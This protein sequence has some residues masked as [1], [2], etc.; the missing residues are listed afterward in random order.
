[1][2][3]SKEPCKCTEGGGGTINF[4]IVC[5]KCGDNKVEVWNSYGE[6]E[7]SVIL[8]CKNCGNKDI[9]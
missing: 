8:K 5:R 2:T 3:T 6:Y 4:A 7:D 9:L 1:M